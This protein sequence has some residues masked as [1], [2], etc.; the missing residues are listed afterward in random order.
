LVCCQFT[1]AEN[2]RRG[3]K[4]V[5]AKQLIA[6]LAFEHFI[7][8][9]CKSMAG[10]PRKDRG[11][12]RVSYDTGAKTLVPDIQLHGVLVDLVYFDQEHCRRIRHQVPMAAEGSALYA[13]RITPSMMQEEKKY[14]LAG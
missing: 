8:S 3:T 7:H 12:D 10:T 2:W 5:S 11:I 6:A 4:G 9:D 1:V 14:R 13:K